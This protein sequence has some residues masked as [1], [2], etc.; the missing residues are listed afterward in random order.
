[1]GSPVK[2]KSKGR[3]NLQKQIVEPVQKQFFTM[4]CDGG[5]I[6]TR[7]EQVRLKK[8]PEQKDKDSVRLYKWQHC[9]LTQQKLTKPIVAC[10]LGFLY[11][12]EVIIEKLLDS[13]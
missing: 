12:K 6:P 4:G 11:S 13:K 9:H 5:T 7:D 10:E 1:M 8:K 3:H 2:A